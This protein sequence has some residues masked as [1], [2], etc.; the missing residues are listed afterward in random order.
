[1]KIGIDI[2]EIIVEFSLGYLELFN[3]QYNKNI[4]FED[5]FSYS[6]CEPLEISREESLK[7]AEEYQNSEEFDNIK[8]V[9]GAQEGINFLGK[10]HDL[11]FITSRPQQIKEKTEIFLKKLFSN[12]N[13]KVFFSGGRT[14]SGISKSEICLAQRI[15][16]LIEDDLLHALDCAEKGIK[17]ILLDKPWNQ[18]VT[19]EN[20]LRAKNW[21]EILKKIKELNLRETKND[22]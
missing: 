20:I 10:T 22:K 15:D 17:V 5:L 11:I 7:L 6:L 4:K 9:P 13:L 8:I 16:I 14:E 21:N 2:D 12:F 19:S 18:K 3:K 1:M